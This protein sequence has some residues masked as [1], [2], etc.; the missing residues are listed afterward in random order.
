[1]I[2][3]GI[4]QY[5]DS[6][7]LVIFNEAGVGGNTFLDTTPQ[8]PAEAVVI[9]HTG[10]A[11]SD[12]HHGYNQPTVQIMVRGGPDPRI[13]YSRSTDIYQAL[14]GLGHTVLP[15]GTKVI[16]CEAVQSAPISLGQD[17]GG[18]HRHAINY[19]LDIYAPTAL[20]PT[21]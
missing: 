20:R 17:T 19:Q 4:A 15:D 9:F 10:S 18:L 21:P 5:L 6:L 2:G 7:G 12:F 1:M 3:T 14:H 11:G 13:S 16:S 8:S